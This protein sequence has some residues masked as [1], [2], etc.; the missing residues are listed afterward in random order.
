M[1]QLIE[2]F[3]EYLNAKDSSPHTVRNYLSDVKQFCQCAAELGFDPLKLNRT[4]IF[5][6]L[7]FLS[8]KYTKHSTIMRKRDSL[9][10]FYKFLVIDKHVVRNEFEL[11]AAMKVE[12]DLPAFLSQTEAARLIDSIAPNP[13]LTDKP[14]LHYDKMRRSGH[15]DEA[16]FLAIRDRALIEVIY[17]AG[18]RAQETANLNWVDVDFRAGFIR[19]NQGKG[20]RDRIVPITESAMEA[21]WKY[22]KASREWFETEPKGNSPIFISR[23]NMRI[24]TRSIQRAVKLRL[25]IAGIDTKMATHGLRHSFATHLMQNGCDIVTI[26]ECLGHASLSNTQKYV[27]VSMVD[28]MNNYNK[29]HPRA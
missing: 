6:Y 21:L 4:S 27:H 28:V 18:T 26:A 15:D 11:F 7:G 14:F 12:R 16:E 8:K 24:T 5:L 2:Q 29:A 17:G 19:V 10:Q 3:T 25:K 23:R 1:Q 22:G 20:R 9:K 13:D